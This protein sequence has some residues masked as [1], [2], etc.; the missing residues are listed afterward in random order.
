[1]ATNAL[2]EWSYRP[3]STET[4]LN[5]T[6]VHSFQQQ[7]GIRGAHFFDGEHCEFVTWDLVVQF[8]SKMKN[9]N[10]PAHVEFEE[11]L[12]HTIANT[13]PKT[14]YVLVR[15]I[16]ENVSIECYRQMGL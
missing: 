5:E 7:N 8:C 6:L 10:N 4:T 12:L 1:M 13:D 16:D 2:T 11:K 9:T 15:Q 14:E 3:S